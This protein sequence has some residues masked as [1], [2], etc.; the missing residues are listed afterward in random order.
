MPDRPQDQRTDLPSFDVLLDG[1]PLAEQY[2]VLSIVVS[3][4]INKLPT[5]RLTLSDGD[6]SKNEFPLSSSKLV[7]PGVKIEIKAGYH[8]DNVSIFKG[9]IV[10]HRLT[11]KGANQSMLRL[12]AKPEYH[13]LAIGRKNALFEDVT[14]SDVMDEILSKS[15]GDHS[16]EATELTH[17]FMVQ[18]QVTDWHF[19]LNRAAVNSQ[20]VMPQLDGVNV[21]VPVIDDSAAYEL[22][23]GSTV[24]DFDLAIESRFQLGG[25]FAKRWSHVDQEVTE[26]EGDLPGTAANGN[27]KSADL[28]T[29][30]DPVLINHAAEDD[31]ELQTWADSLLLHSELS[32]IQGNISGPGYAGVFPGKTISLVGVN[33]R[34][35]GT[36]FVSGVRHEL[37]KGNWVTDF[38][39]GLDSEF[40]HD[41]LGDTVSSGST[42]GH[43]NQVMPGISNLYTGKVMSLEDDDGEDRVQVHVP[44]LHPDSSGT[45]CRRMAPDAGDGRGLVFR[46]EIDDEVVVGFIHGDPRYG[47]MLGMVHSSALP[48]PIEAADDNHIKG[49]V[50]RSEMKLTFDDENSIVTLETP[51]GH[52]LTLDDDEGAV[53]I[54]DSNDNTLVMDKDGIV[55]ESAGDF[56]ITAQG[57][58]TVEGTDVTLNAQGSFG[59]EAGSAAEL[60]CSGQTTIEGAIVAIN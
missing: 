36:A 47:I 28:T 34:F 1:S 50:S 30:D 51:A 46:P 45:W 48:S 55:L 13:S 14:D 18:N 16:V 52:T 10:N 53:S 2:P 40:L 12:E 11:V 56:S 9:V 6:V 4:Q 29:A 39:V 17:P 57:N 8:D 24:L 31:A 21:G 37:S 26:A 59:A 5:A 38:Q 41:M 44:G 23:Y 43:Q 7:I 3:S 19:V 33:D 35:N 15:A 54:K 58:V 22:E 60:K 49:F 32:R 27:L 42:A 25:A 20:L